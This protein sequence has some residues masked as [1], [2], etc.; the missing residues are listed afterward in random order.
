MAA[1]AEREWALHGFHKLDAPEAAV[2]VGLGEATFSAEAVEVNRAQLAAPTAGNWEVRIFTI[3]RR[4]GSFGGRA[5][6]FHLFFSGRKLPTSQQGRC[7][8]ATVRQII[9]TTSRRRAS[10]TLGQNVS[11]YQQ[12]EDR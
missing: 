7:E 1:K 3:R 2:G 10:S 4:H 6:L 12:Q 5:N 9:P 8:P 11:P